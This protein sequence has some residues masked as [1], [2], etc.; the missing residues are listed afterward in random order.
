MRPV[1]ELW[2][3]SDQS[4]AYLLLMQF[5]LF[6]PPREEEQQS[7]KNKHTPGTEGDRRKLIRC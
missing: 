7:M 1:N 3:Q 4:G 2:F 6:T 5:I